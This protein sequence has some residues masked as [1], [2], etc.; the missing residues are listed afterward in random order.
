MRGL[1]GAGRWVRPGRFYGVVNCPLSMVRRGNFWTDG[2]VCWGMAEARL[3][4]APR[5]AVLRRRVVRRGVLAVLILV[6]AGVGWWWRGAIGARVGLMY[7]QRECLTFSLPGDRVV[8]EEKVTGAE[9]LPGPGVS[10]IAKNRPACWGK[11][12]G[13]GWTP[14]TFA[15]GEAIVFLHGMR[16]RAG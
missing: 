6:V 15:S 2:R 13:A 5:P 3:E 11:Y 7:W 9:V 4:Y 1:A 12:I 8:Y 14:G 10:V 16:S